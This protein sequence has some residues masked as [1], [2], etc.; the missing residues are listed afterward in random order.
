MSKK[1]VIVESPAK[2][3]TIKRF[4][5][6]DF[7]ITA[8]MGHVRD[9][10]EK[11]LGIDIQ[12]GFEP[13][14]TETR[15]KIV[16]QLKSSAKGVTDIYL[17][18][19]PDREGEAIAW[20][21]KELLQDKKGKIEFHRVAFHEITKSAVAKAFETPGEINTS[22]VDSQQARRILD[23]IVG[24]QVSPLLWS[25]V[26]RGV[27][28]GRVQ[29]V[30]LRIICE[31]E[32]EIEAFEPQ[33]YWVFGIDFEHTLTPAPDNKFTTKL[34]KIDGK[35]AEV[36]TGEEALELFTMLQNSPEFKVSSV[37]VKPQTRNAPPPFITSTL[38]QNAGTS[39]S[40]T[41]RIAQQLYEGIDIGSGGPTGL[42]TY[43][44]TD[45]VA[46]ASEAQNAC[47]GFILAEYGDAYAPAKQ[48]NFKVSASAQAAH[49]AIRP[50]DVTFTPEKAAKFLDGDQLRLYTMIWKR[51]VAS[52]MAP[53]RLQKTTVNV[54][55]TQG[56]KTCTFQA[57]A[58]VTQFPGFMVLAGTK[59]EDSENKNAEVLGKISEGDNCKPAD[60]TKEQ[61]FTEP[62]P[63]YSEPSL[64]RELES[65]GI[66]RPSTYASIVMTIQTRDYCRK[67]GGKLVPTEIGFQVNDYLVAKLPVLFEIGFTAEMEKQ[68][69]TIEEGK[70][71]WK[72]MLQNFY[73]NFAKWLNDAKFAGA[74][75]NAKAEALLALMENVTT[76]AEPEKS[77]R[78]TYD[79]KKF[80][81]SLKDQFEKDKSMT[82]KQ[83]GALL[84]LALKY[85]EQISGF[86]DFVTEFS[87]ADDVA[88]IQKLI[89]DR[90]AAAKQRQAN[91]NS[92]DFLKL[93]EAFD[94]FDNVE[95]DEPVKKGARTFDD[96]KFFNSLK[97]QMESGKAL[98]EKQMNAFRRIASKYAEKTGQ[99]EKLN[100]LLKLDEINAAAAAGN[101]E[102]EALLAQ[103][104]NVTK[105]AEPVT[106]GKRTFDDKSFFESLKKQYNDRKTLSS[107]QIF[108]LK[109]IAAK[110][111]EK[112]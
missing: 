107:R 75:E 46:V 74:P 77:G 94:L 103:M 33:E 66:G 44:R 69:D 87:C 71:N 11:S 82:E 38:Q 92:E 99:E 98:S 105:W 54:Q 112:K 73:D 55:N 88:E 90:A 78:R 10:P 30:A 34:V 65:N 106:K 35:K 39:A 31:R 29:S 42:I 64:I 20:H 83:W 79:D 81:T 70:L 58:I 101:P 91:L 24:Y 22:L 89:D 48:R 6:S 27:S 62:P 1:L 28:A 53:A 61:K 110:Y 40:R 18:P 47:R 16:S 50:T 5:G 97:K 72:T 49:E 59:K 13:A 9:L 23:R 109:K 84:Q 100:S 37:E 111:A 76:W 21:L 80:F 26:K 104:A 15:K 2:A 96:Q 67:D 52:Q 17:A 93:K 7:E 68:L 45:S 95:W 57:T 43:M 32:R 63:R 3:R 56:A 12:N 51:F 86:D 19:D 4:L 36:H 60:I 108:A 14:Y 102:V 41:M 85:K 25:K 8:S